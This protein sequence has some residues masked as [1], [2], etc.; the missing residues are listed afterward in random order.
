M[1]RVE[2]HTKHA[3]RK[4]RIKHRTQGAWYSRLLHPARRRSG[5]I[6]DPKTRRA[7]ERIIHNSS[8]SHCCM[9]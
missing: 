9:Q 3:Q 5:L 7:G 8:T 2:T 6:S 1:T 4:P